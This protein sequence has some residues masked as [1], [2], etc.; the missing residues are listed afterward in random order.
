MIQQS[1]FWAYIQ[2]NYDLKR[3]SILIFIA[4]LFIAVKTRKQPKYSLT[5]D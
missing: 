1:Y 2:T 3:H 5:D 4:A